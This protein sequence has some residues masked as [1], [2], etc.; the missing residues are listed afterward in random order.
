MATNQQQTIDE[1]LRIL[2][3]RF[4]QVDENKL[5]RLY[6]RHN[7]NIEKVNMKFLINI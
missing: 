1:Q 2:K 3:E 5:T 4:P 6:Q 7:G